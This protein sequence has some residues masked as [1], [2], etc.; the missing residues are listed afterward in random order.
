M[1]RLQ[2][3]MATLLGFIT[4]LAFSLASIANAIPYNGKSSVPGYVVVGVWI[5]I[6]CFGSAVG[7][8][9]SGIAFN[10]P[11]KGTIGGGLLAV[12]AVMTLPYSMRGIHAF[13]Q[14]SFPLQ[15]A[16]VAT[17][18]FLLGWLCHLFWAAFMN[19]ARKR[20]PNLS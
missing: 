7:M 20:E 15:L 2:T 1:P 13:L 8:V 9:V 10:K 6:V 11:W 12:A 4:L 17:A 19:R 14:L 18:A 5:G 3:N 16:L